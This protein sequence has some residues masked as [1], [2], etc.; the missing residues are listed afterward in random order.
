MEGLGSHRAEEG[1]LP[2]QSHRS[3]SSPELDAQ[4]LSRALPKSE[5]QTRPPRR[6]QRRSHAGVPVATR[7]ARLETPYKRSL[8]AS[9][10]LGGTETYNCRGGSREYIPA[11]HSLLKAKQLP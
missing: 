6:I 4:L 2:Y 5:V 9:K 3:R 8:G 10:V 11:M 1:P 7:A